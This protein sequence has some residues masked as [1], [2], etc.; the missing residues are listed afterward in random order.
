LIKIREVIDRILAYH[1]AISADKPTCD[2][3]KSGNPEDECT[4]IVTSIQASVDVIRKTQERGANLIIVHEPTF[5]THMDQTQWL[6]DNEVYQKKLALL[7]RYGIAVWRDHDHIHAH[8]PDGIMTGIA[9]QLGWTDYAVN[10]SGFH[11]TFILPETTARDV[12]K[13]MKARFGLNA[14]RAIGNLDAKITKVCFVGHIISDEQAVTK[15]INDENIEVAVALEAFDW[16]TSSYIHDAGQLGLHKALL[17]CG[18][19][20][21][22]EAGMQWAIH[23]IHDL[24]P[25][26][27]VTFIRC[28]DLYQYVL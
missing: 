24:V 1:P 21:T 13:L 16:T 28:A 23:W 11:Y 14:V 20:N 8:H 3:F 9:A 4:G 12:A 2:G 7:K 15:R 5:Y 6:E 25:E 22:E 17:L 27:P 26:V 19:M 10:H 18:H